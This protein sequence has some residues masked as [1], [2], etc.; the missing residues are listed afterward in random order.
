MSLDRVVV[1][2][3][4]LAGCGKS[5]DAVNAKPPEIGDV[6]AATTA[7]LALK[8]NRGTASIELPAGMIA[9][10]Q[11]REW[12]RW[13]FTNTDGSSATIAVESRT[14]LLDMNV[15]AGQHVRR[16]VTAIGD[17]QPPSATKELSDGALLTFVTADGDTVKTFVARAKQGWTVECRASVLRGGS[18]LKAWAD[19]TCLSL[20]IDTVN[21][22]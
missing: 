1:T 13:A 14:A 19:R 3:V 16:Y 21:P 8:L 11:Q 20:T 10:D 7:R 17:P 5:D 15:G 2:A 9:N 18:A 12:Q 4:L 6:A 22:G